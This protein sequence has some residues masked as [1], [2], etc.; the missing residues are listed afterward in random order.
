MISPE[1]EPITPYIQRVSSLYK[2]CGVSS[3]I[4]AGSSGSY[5]H[6]AD[7]I[8][9]MKNYIPLDI[10][11]RAKEAAREFPVFSADQALFPSWNKDRC[12]RPNMALR[13]DDRLK[14]KAMG[15][16]E[17][18]LGHDTVEL[19]YV[20]QLRDSEQT[21]ALALLL[22]YAQLHLMDG[23][24]N[25]RLITDQLEALL[26]QKGLEGLFD[27]GDVRSSLARPRRQEILACINRYRKLFFA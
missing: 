22:Q 13:R 27:R 1:E 24:K 14:S 12:P 2:D 19:R 26:D 15:T 21:M 8:I 17:L 11:A 9:Q 6:V 3:I 16:N 4:V 10:T 7:T 18:S 23:K 20:E 25:L 5:F